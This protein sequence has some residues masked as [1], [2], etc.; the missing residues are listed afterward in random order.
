MIWCC[1]YQSR[2]IWEFGRKKELIVLG[3][4]QDSDNGHFVLNRIICTDCVTFVS[5]V[6]EIKQSFS[7]NI[8]VKI[9]KQERKITGILGFVQ[10]WV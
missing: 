4:L 1:V 7:T 8:A 3:F 5:F 10:S 6:M 9:E 2:I